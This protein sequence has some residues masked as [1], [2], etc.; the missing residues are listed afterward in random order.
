MRTASRAP[1]HP[2]HVAFA[3]AFTGAALAAGY[4]AFGL[5]TTL[6]FTAG[7]A[8][9]LLLWLLLPTRGNWTDIRWPFWIAMGLFAAHRVEE[10]QSG[11]FAMLARVTDVSTPDVA[12]PAV[13]GLL[14][15]S[16]GGW[17]AV[18]FLMGRRDHPLASYFAWSFFASMGITEL[19]HWVVFPFIQGPG[20]HAV[21][22][23]WT[24]LVL[25]P[26]AWWGMWRLCQGS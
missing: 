15:L 22:G 13:I 11:F 26:V 19:A 10:K 23:M 24:V 5:L 20:I 3:V 17:L 2:A 7:L 4:A 12:S 25:A 18:P 16:V 6:V 9:G 8:G 21:P 1:L 14:I